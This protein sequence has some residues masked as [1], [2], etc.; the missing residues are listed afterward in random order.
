MWKWLSGL[1]LIVVVLLAPTPALADTSDDITVTV[2]G[3][4]VAPAPSGLTLTYIND[5]EVGISWVKGSAAVPE[6]VGTNSTIVNTMIRVKWGA[7]PASRS[8]GYLVYYGDGTSYNDTNIDLTSLTLISWYRAWTET[9]FYDVDGDIISSIWDES[10]ITGE[11]N[12]MSLSWVFMILA[13]LAIAL[14][15][16]MFFTRQAMLG[17]PCGIFWAILGGFSYIQST[18]T[19][20]ILYMVFFAS[21]GMAIFT[22]FAAFA[23]R[24][25]KE[26][27][28]EGDSF[29]DE[30]KD[31]VVFIDEGA[32]PAEAKQYYDEYGNPRYRKQEGKPEEDAGPR[33]RALHNRAE[34]RRERWE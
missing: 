4:L 12:F 14:T 6:P 11:A 26:E 2:V 30:G 3:Y 24:T 23:L 27:L 32:S 22:I 8:D 16:A 10:G 21:F 19:W 34:K 25:K 17:F 28:R 31:D 33:A 1:L 9:V 29:I 18:A 13:L 20:D 7:A 15:V 5:Y